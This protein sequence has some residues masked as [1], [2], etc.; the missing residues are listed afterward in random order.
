MQH[1]L[2]LNVIV[3][4]DNYDEVRDYIQNT[5]KNSADFVKII[6]VVNK[7]TKQK[8][9]ELRREFSSD[10]LTIK[11]YG[12]NIGYLNSL[13]YV[14]DEVNVDSYKYFILSNT[15]IEYVTPNFF[16]E[17]ISKSYNAE[18]GCIAPDV[19]STLTK[20]HSNPH[21][22]GR[23][24]KRRLERT[25]FIFAHPFLAQI[26]MKLSWLRTLK[27]SDKKDSCIVYSPHGCYMI[28]TN[29]VAHIIKG[30]RYAVKMYTEEGWIAETLRN[31]ALKCYYD[32]TISVLHKEHGTTDKLGIK[33][34]AK[35]F[36]E[37]LYNLID[38]FYEKE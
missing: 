5:I 19:Y 28:L 13:L 23:L 12:E 25:A 18:I 14:L 29:R 4:Y 22:M 11:N 38:E 32:A 24:S 33:K 10:V 15:D 9:Q 35:M 7:D 8:E 27:K 31:N 30:K 34:Q 20:T 3:L 37:S 6:L 1:D 17:V 16:A 2:C 26:Y 21:Y 36:S